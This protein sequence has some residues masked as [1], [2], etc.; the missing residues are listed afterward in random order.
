MSV[1][2][3]LNDRHYDTRNF[4][5]NNNY[6][7]I[8]VDKKQLEINKG[9][10]E[11]GNDKLYIKFDHIQT[12]L[13]YAKLYNNNE[14]YEN[15]YKII[16]G[17]FY[18]DNNFFLFKKLTNEGKLIGHKIHKVQKSELYSKLDR[19]Y[20]SNYYNDISKTSFLLNKQIKDRY[21]R[22]VP[23]LEIKYDYK[24]NNEELYFFSSIKTYFDI[25]YK[26]EILRFDKT[27]EKVIIIK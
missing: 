17:H 12:L 8:L 22:D 19:L 25:D 10:Y 21:K 26:D 11:N 4:D 3:T 2:T 18:N 7:A 16:Y 20:F 9:I 14:L 27:N 15:G 24:E 23:T 5:L 6:Y 13:I 1:I